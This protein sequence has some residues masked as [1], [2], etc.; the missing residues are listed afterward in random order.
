MALRINGA[1]VMANGR[2]WGVEVDGETVECPTYDVAERLADQNDKP[3]KVRY[4][5]ITDWTDAR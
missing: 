3:V 2:D 5:Y 4:H 1:V